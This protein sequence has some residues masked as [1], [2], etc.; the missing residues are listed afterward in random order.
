MIPSLCRAALSGLLQRTVASSDGSRR[1]VMLQMRVCRPS[2]PS[3]NVPSGIAATCR[4]RV[5]RVVDVHCVSSAC[6][7]GGC[8]RT[9]LPQHASQN[10]S[11]K[12]GGSPPLE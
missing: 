10:S 3:P 11:T 7:G 2:T 1:H 6:L 5:D 8:S 9:D 12:A 4:V